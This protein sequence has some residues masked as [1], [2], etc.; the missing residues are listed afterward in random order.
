MT[1]HEQAFF[2]FNDQPT[3]KSNVIDHPAKAGEDQLHMNAYADALTEFIRDVQSPLT[4]A[5]QGEWGSGKTSLMNALR[6]KLVDDK[7]APYLGIWINTWQYALMSDAE[8]AIRHILLGIIGQVSDTA[9]TTAEERVTIF[10]KLARVG[11]GVVSDIFKKYSGVDVEKNLK[12]WNANEAVPAKSGVEDLKDELATLVVKALAATPDKR[13]FLFFIDDLDRID[14][15]VAVQIL[16]LLKNVFDIPKC[17]FVLAIDFDVV[18]KGLKPKFGA[19]TDENEREFRS[20]FEK[21]IQLPFSMPIASYKIDDFLMDSLADI[22]Y[23][24]AKEKV[25]KSLCEALTAYALDSVG[26]NPRS[27]KRLINYLSLMRVLIG[28][29]KDQQDDAD[30]SAWK[31]VLFALVSL[32]I[33]YQKLYVALLAMPDFPNWGEAFEQKWRIPA[34]KEGEKEKLEKMTEFDEHWEQMLFRFCRIDPFLEARAPNVSRILNRIKTRIEDARQPVGEIVKWLI[35]LSVVTSV[36]S[37]PAQAAAPENFSKSQ[38]LKDFRDCTLGMS[39]PQDCW[40]ANLGENTAIT[41]QQVRFQSNFACSLWNC[42][43]DGLKDNRN[44]LGILVF[45]IFHD[46]KE[47][48]LKIAG[49]FYGRTSE[50]DPSAGIDF[51]AHMEEV[52]ATEDDYRAAWEPFGVIANIGHNVGAGIGMDDL[53]W[54]ITVPFKDHDEL[55]SDA[56]SQKLRGSLAAVAAAFASLLKYRVSVNP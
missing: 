1:S 19:M 17:I 5:L 8:E 6:Q 25:D 38:Y 44:Y 13:G 42:S 10:K 11:G 36:K 31:D 16:E 46:G 41:S 53:W 26:T 3:M 9:K 35:S 29:T 32:Q 45:H 37:E 20:F 49:A 55:V 24:D 47:F 18:V 22:G 40:R 4:I 56:F 48:Q 2:S 12:E 15:P 14:P 33:Q 30:F 43:I 52:A 28:K 34:L 51:G 21:I 50:N 39:W 23:L 27:L 7:D 54:N